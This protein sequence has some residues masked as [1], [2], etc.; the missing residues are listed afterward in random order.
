MI[1]R[2][3][4][5]S[6]VENMKKDNNTFGRLHHGLVDT[7]FRYNYRDRKGI[8]ISKMLKNNKEHHDVL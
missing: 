2:M 5:N 8:Y 4:K 3:N 6:D 1:K 7:I